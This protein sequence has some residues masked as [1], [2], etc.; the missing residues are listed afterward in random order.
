MDG[1][2]KNNP[3]LTAFGIRR[4]TSMGALCVSDKRFFKI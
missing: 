2:K 1:A 4:P 3:T